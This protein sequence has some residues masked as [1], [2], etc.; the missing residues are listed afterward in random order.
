MQ[1]P[2]CLSLETTHTRKACEHDVTVKGAEPE[3]TI[4]ISAPCSGYCIYSTAIH[5]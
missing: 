4:P 3:V 5:A 1:Y 2:P